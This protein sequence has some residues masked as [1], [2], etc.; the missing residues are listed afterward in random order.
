MQKPTFI[1]RIF[2]WIYPFTLAKVSSKVS[3]TL[4]VNLQYGK[5]VIDSPQANYSYGNLHLVFQKAIQQLQLNKNKEY[6]VLILGFGAGSIAQILLQEE[7]IKAEITGV[8]LDEKMI[9]LAKEYSK[10]I[11]KNT[12]IF[13]DDAFHFI[14]TDTNTY[15][16]IFIDLF[17]DTSVPNRFQSKAFLELVQKRLKPNAQVLMNTM[18]NN[19]KLK[20]NWQSVFQETKQIV[21]QENKILHFINK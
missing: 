14:H 21:I 5:V 4:E 13:I 12:K 18:Q 1:Q 20:N 11:N 3:G 15:D 17:I 2:S 19:E 9:N 6:Q 16:L 10:S 8:E 7:K